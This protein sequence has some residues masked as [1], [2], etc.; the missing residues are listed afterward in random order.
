MLLAVKMVESLFLFSFYSSLSFK[1]FVKIF[2]FSNVAYVGSFF[3]LVDLAHF[4]NL[5]LGLRVCAFSI[6]KLCPSG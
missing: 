3:L 1:N 2:E 6:G 4:F 5:K